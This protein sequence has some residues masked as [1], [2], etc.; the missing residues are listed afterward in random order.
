[1]LESD[2]YTFI[3]NKEIEFTT[4][5]GRKDLGLGTLVNVTDGGDGLNHSEYRNKKLSELH[6]NRVRRPRTEE[7][8]LTLSKSVKAYFANNPSARQNM[9]EKTKAYFENN[10]EARKRKPRSQETKDKI[11]KSLKQRNETERNR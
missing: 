4:L 8:K 7:E 2:D 10:P 1:M 6:R 11:S 3:K 5:Y 9:V